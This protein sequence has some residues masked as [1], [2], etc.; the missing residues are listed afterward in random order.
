MKMWISE[1]NGVQGRTTWERWEG[2]V[3]PV[4][5]WQ[6]RV[7]CSSDNNCARR[8]IHG[9]EFVDRKKIMSIH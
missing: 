4:D 3:R 1:V 8:E 7:T 5:E 2:S 9:K 6:G